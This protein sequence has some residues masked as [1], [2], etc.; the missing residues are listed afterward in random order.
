MRTNNGAE[1]LSSIQVLVISPSQE[2]RLALQKRAHCERIAT[3]TLQLTFGSSQAPGKR[4]YP[5]RVV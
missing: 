2:N 5:D 1:E 3:Y 4:G